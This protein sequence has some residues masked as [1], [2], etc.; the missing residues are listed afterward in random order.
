[1]TDLHIER[2]FR[3][4][5]EAAATFC[6]VQ[7]QLDSRYRLLKDEFYPSFPVYASLT[8]AL[9]IKS[10]LYRLLWNLMHFTSFSL[11]I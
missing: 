5:P 4:S 10:I 8:I 11:F 1:M 6:N 9:F 2:A 3:I 7:C